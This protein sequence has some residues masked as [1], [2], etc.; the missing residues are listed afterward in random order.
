MKK[1]I[2]KYFSKAID[3]IKEVLADGSTSKEIP[4]EYQGYIA[5]FGSS[6]L[7]MGLL[8]T[9]AVYA[10]QDSGSAEHRHKILLVLAKTIH[11]TIGNQLS[12]DGKGALNGTA[13]HFFTAVAQKD[14]LQH[15]LKDPL[16]D[17]AV[18]VKLCLRTF[19]LTKP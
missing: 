13:E 17:A 7:Q 14:S 19:K 3:A 8:P 2:E 1:R 18:A 10:D 4:R 16:L 15:E 11:G 6:V 9:L 12:N 5:A